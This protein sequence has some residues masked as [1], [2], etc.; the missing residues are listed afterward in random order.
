MPPRIS[1]SS[2]THL[3]ETATKAP[4]VTWSSSFKSSGSR[5][6]YRN[7][8]QCSAMHRTAASGSQAAICL[9]FK[10]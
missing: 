10:C 8:V 3:C 5:L 7:C 2:L 1:S 9:R 4:A 6:R